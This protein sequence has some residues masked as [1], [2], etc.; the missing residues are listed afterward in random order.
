MNK[1]SLATIQIVD[2]F[3]EPIAKAHYE[4]KNQHTG[5]LIATGA[6]NAKG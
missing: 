5:Q 4:V 3:G 6:T 2:L 1:K